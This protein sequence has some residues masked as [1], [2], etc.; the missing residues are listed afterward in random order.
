MAQWSQRGP[1]A[2]A[3]PAPAKEIRITTR[4]SQKDRLAAEKE[5][6]SDLVAGI[7]RIGIPWAVVQVAGVWEHPVPVPYICFTC[8]RRRDEARRAAG[9]GL[10]AVKPTGEEADA[11]DA[12]APIV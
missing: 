7:C 2:S 12:V 5:I 9:N 6:R 11:I 1:V 8:S 10:P 3:R 4:R